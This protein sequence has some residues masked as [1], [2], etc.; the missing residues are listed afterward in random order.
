[1]SIPTLAG[2]SASMITTAR[3]RSRVLFA[4]PENGIPVVFVHGNLTSATFWEE[5][6]LAMPAD[7]RSIALD[8]RGFGEADPAAIVDGQRGL[9]DLAEDVVALLDTLGIAQAHV[10]GHSMGGG[11]LWQLML[12]A[13][14][15]LRSATL[16]APVSPFGFGGSKD[17]Q[18]NL[19]AAD[20]AGSGGGVANPQYTQLLRDGERGAGEMSPR[21][22]MNGFYWKPPYLSPR[23]EDLLSSVLQTHTGE[24]DYPG[25]AVASENWPGVAPGRWGILNAMAPNYQPDWSALYANAVKP[26]T[27]WLHGDSDQVIAD[28][29]MFDLATFGKLGIIP[30]YPG[31][32][33]C[34]PQ[35][36]IAQIRHVLDN[37]AAAGAT[38]REVL[39][40]DCGHTPFVE[41]A[42]EFNAALHEFLAQA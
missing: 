28:E 32:A 30:G 37:Y 12:N 36:M 33:V 27:L 23:E 18:G 3:L 7:Y 42:A 39:L 10:V 34:P 35:P 26:P 25:D 2:I 11:V 1:M 31:E 8:Q 24:R 29:S 15:R 40:E 41:K 21:A 5:T 14:Q 9:A 22:V 6:M 13:P 19:C 16:V 38:V 4:G 20:G 17:A